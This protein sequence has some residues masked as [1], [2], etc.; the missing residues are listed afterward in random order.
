MRLGSKILALVLAACLW[1]PILQLF[2]RPAARADAPG[3]TSRLAAALV[4]H[5][6][7]LW[8][9]G[10]R[11]TSNLMAANPEW[12]LMHRMFDVLAFANVALAEPARAPRMLRA[13]DTIVDGALAIEAARGQAHY[14]LPYVRDGH[15]RDPS[16]RSLF[17]DG[18]LA[19]MLAARAQVAPDPRHRAELDLRVARVI[20]Q[21]EGAPALLAESYPDEGWTFCNVVALVAIRLHDGLGGVDH[22]ALVARWI[23][24]ARVHLIEPTTG[25]L[26]S[27]F[28]FHGRPQ[29]GPEG[30]TIWLVASFLKALDPA[31]AADQYARAHRQLERHLLGFAWATEWPAALPHH[32][33]I[34]SGPSVPLVDANAGS[35]GLALVAAGAFGDTAFLH[36]LVASLELA[37][38]PVDATDGRH[39]AAGNDLA[40]AVAAYALVQ[41]PLFAR[42][43]VTR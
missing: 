40:D 31:F 22:R 1:L 24:S 27:S 29:E 15:F 5:Q 14:L 4:E 23:A 36:G 26:A 21:L 35:S 42:A 8:L 20:A 32:D 33:D 11:P 34:D 37:A 3:G 43:G 16:G 2:F 9:D 38:F 17:V 28:D 12:A 10:A 7:A 41:G 39:Y 13:I 25:L 6:A 30:S 18:E 19:L